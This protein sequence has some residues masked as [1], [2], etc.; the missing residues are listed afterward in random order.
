MTKIVAN[1]PQ[2]VTDNQWLLTWQ[3][4]SRSDVV[5]ALLDGDPHKVNPF[6]KESPLAQFSK[7]DVQSNGLIL[8]LSRVSDDVK[9]IEFT[10]DSLTEGERSWSL[11]GLNTGEI[12]QNESVEVP[13]DAPCLLLTMTRSEG[14]WSFTA[15]DQ[16]LG[17]QADVELDDQIPEAY[18]ALVV[19]ATARN[20]AQSRDNFS[21]I[22]DCSLSTR[23]AESR[24]DFQ[25]ILAVL[26]AIAAAA[27]LRPLSVSYHGLV[28]ERL[29]VEDDLEQLHSKLY[30]DALSKASN[31]PALHALVPTSVS[32]LRRGSVCYV[33]TDSMFFYDEDLTDEL[34]AQGIELRVLLLSSQGAK[35]QINEGEGIRLLSL[36]SLESLDEKAVLERFS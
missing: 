27:N 21:A 16:V 19:R 17:E 18:R 15:R 11:E 13:A 3:G 35:F 5:T 28:E 33:I 32:K 30:A 9:K 36:G 1:R 25:K 14:M 20:L 7:P 34:I 23:T 2:E 31:A 4:A 6:S 12:W 29:T 24:G 22:V 8:D 26:V 10:I